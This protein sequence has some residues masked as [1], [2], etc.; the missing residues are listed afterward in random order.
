MVI[1]TGVQQFSVERCTDEKGFEFEAIGRASTASG[2]QEFDIQQTTITTTGTQKTKIVRL[3]LSKG[4]ADFSSI[5][6]IV[7]SE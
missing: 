7:V 1:S 2:S 4:F 3:I 5:R 6:K